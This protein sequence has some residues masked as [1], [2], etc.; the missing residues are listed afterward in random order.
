MSASTSAVHAVSVSS[1]AWRRAK[2]LSSSGS[3]SSD[4]IDA[5]STSTGIT[6]SRRSSA[7]AIST[8]THSVAC[9]SRPITAISA[10]ERPSASSMTST[11]SAPGSVLSRS[12]KTL[13]GP[14]RAASRS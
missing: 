9:Q 8:R 12:L 7:A 10:S 2:P 13:S 11:K 6:R 3:A 1:T 4:G 14:K 5:P